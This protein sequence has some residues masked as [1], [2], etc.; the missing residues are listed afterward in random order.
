MKRPSMQ[1]L[2]LDCLQQELAAE[3]EMDLVLKTIQQRKCKSRSQS[4][5]RSHLKS[6]GR[7]C[8]LSPESSPLRRAPRA[9][10]TRKAQTVCCSLLQA[11]AAQAV[12]CRLECQATLQASECRSHVASQLRD[13]EASLRDPANSIPEAL[14]DKEGEAELQSSEYRT[15][16]VSHLRDRE[17]LLRDVE[18]SQPRALTEKAREVDTDTLE[19]T[20]AYL[21]P[22][23]ASLEPVHGSSPRNRGSISSPSSPIRTRC[24]ASPL[25]RRSPRSAASSPVAQRTPNRACVLCRARTA[26]GELWTWEE[27]MRPH[28]HMRRAPTTT[29]GRPILSPRK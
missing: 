13:L 20:I 9:R 22:L 15:Q 12:V 3:H 24:V 17:A 1:A 18:S 28:M 10:H 7:C 27:E 14:T 25:S 16:V 21:E 29:K 23:E 2:L 4:V 8:P 5:D 6:P 11:A 26:V 19:E